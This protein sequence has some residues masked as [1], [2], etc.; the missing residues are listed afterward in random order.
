MKK[1]LSTSLIP[2]IGITLILIAV[3]SRRLFIRNY[4]MDSTLSFLAGFAVIVLCFLV[5]KVYLKN[6]K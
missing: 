3:L 6:K 4:S 1:P 2:I 5:L